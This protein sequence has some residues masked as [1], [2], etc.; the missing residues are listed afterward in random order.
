MSALEKL[1]ARMKADE[2]SK[3]ASK[4][5]NDAVVEKAASSGSSASVTTGRTKVTSD[6]AISRAKSA[7]DSAQEVYQKEADS[8]MYQLA[9]GATAP[10]G[11]DP[12][13]F[14]EQLADLRMAALAKTPDLGSLTRK[15]L[16]NLRENEELTHLLTDDQLHIVIEGALAGANVEIKDA[17]KSKG[18]SNLKSQVDSLSA[19]DFDL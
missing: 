16:V 10:E 5:N 11:V 6:S 8:G 15:L 4:T 1:R 3:S 19:D 7:L 14:F 9:A 12:D 18:L 17:K 13:S 2:Q